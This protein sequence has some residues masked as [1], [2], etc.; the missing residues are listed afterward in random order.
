MVQIELFGSAGMRHDQSCFIR[1]SPRR[2]SIRPST[3]RGDEFLVDGPRGLPMV[4]S[5]SPGLHPCQG[6]GG[7]L[8]VRAR[9]GKQPEKAGVS[10]SH[11]RDDGGCRPDVMPCKLLI[12]LG[13]CDSMPEP[14]RPV[15]SSLGESG[16]FVGRSSCD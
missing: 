10:S 14:S 8:Q 3:M 6:M 1:M 16:T 4:G 7:G 5:R 9:H 12:P 13:S 2:D 11:D 15:S